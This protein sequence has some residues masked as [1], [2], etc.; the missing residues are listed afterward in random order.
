MLEA[1][2]GVLEDENGEVQDEEFV[3]QAKEG[4]QLAEVRCVAG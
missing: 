2:E 3:F 1:K 4:V